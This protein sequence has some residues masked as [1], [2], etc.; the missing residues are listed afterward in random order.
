M[1]A[2]IINGEIQKEAMVGHIR[3]NMDITFP[4]NN[5]YQFLVDVINNAST[6]KT[7]NWMI[8]KVPSGKIDT[9]KVGRRKLRAADDNSNDNPTG[10]GAVTTG[11][12]DYAV[13]KVFW[14]EWIKNDDV[15]YNAI[16]QAQ[17]IMPQEGITDTADV[18]AL[19]IQMLQKQFA[20]DLQDLAFNGDTEHDVTD[21]DKDFLRIVDGF[22]K[23]MMKSP[24]KTDLTTNPLTI[25][26]MVNHVQLVPEEY[27][28]NYDHDYVWLMGRQT[29]DKIAA[30]L[31]NRTTGL[32]DTLL[33]NGRVEKVA[34]YPVEIVAGLQGPLKTPGT[35]TDGRK[36]FIALTP[37]SNLVPIMTQDL[38]YTRTGEGALAAKKDS[39]YHIIHA[40]L[41][42]VVRDVNAVAYM[43][44]ERI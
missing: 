17:S 3:K 5:A 11:S 6:L 25:A 10:V 23:K 34:G 24:Y 2:L 27:K 9:L 26:D 4:A 7:L 39:T 12:I 41:D 22:V 15:I 33:V 1:G 31:A 14:D 35:Y 42:C 44:G 40:Y 28:N 8:K 20:M 37:R 29:H 36:G 13:K 18:E 30:L 38:K 19:I 43:V 16:R 21:P 32:G